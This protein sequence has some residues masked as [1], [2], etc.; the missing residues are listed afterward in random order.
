MTTAVLVVAQTVALAWGALLLGPALAGLVTGR[1]G[2]VDVAP[3]VVGIGAAF[4]ARAALV[5][6]TEWRAHRAATRVVAEL[7]TRVLAHTAALGPRWLATA[8]A[9]T[10]TLL[11]RGLDA[12]EPYVVRFLPQLLQTAI[13]TPAL[14]VVVATQDLL[15]AVTL[16]VALP[17]IP[18]FMWLIGVA[19]QRT[20]ERRLAAQQRL[21]SRLLDLVAGLP[22]LRA[23]GRARGT[24]ARVHDLAEGERRG[25]MATL[26]IAFLS[27]AVLEAAATLT[28][29]LVAVGV[30][31]RLVTGD[32]DLAVGLTVLVLAP[33]VLAPL[34]GVGTQFHASA[35]GVAAVERAMAVL[36]EPL[37][38]AGTAAP[39]DVVEIRLDGVGVDAGER[40]YR[41]PDDLTLSVRAGRVTVLRG[42]SGSGKTTAALVL[43]GLQSPDGGT[44]RL[45]TAQGWRDLADV[46]PVAWHRLLAW[47]PQAP[48]LEPGTVAEALGSDPSHPGVA[49]ASAL[50]GLDAVVADLPQ[51]W[52]TGLGTGG[53]G[54][55]AGQRQRLVL[56]RGVASVDARFLVLDEPTAH[57][58]SASLH[59]VRATVRAAT[60]VGR[61]VL[62]ISHSPELVDL[63]DDVVDLTSTAV[64]A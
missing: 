51:G 50:T 29:A 48:V 3:A 43:L 2:W 7:R 42:P 37:P 17:L 47:V 49:A 22:T 61:G 58:D 25:T 15:A 10:A 30:G 13:L 57:L 39:G 27:G 54:M 19:T 8:G 63:A 32:L 16:A 64:P 33:E 4:G 41:A 60:A 55:S 5:A 6:A 1:L 21:A 52:G 24:V 26:R 12:L 38:R 9:D 20:A 45:R 14:L 36:D 34:R 18:V 28:V 31:L 23:L 46:D 56:T 62:L 40:G 59:Q 35:D 44:V 11:T 53:R